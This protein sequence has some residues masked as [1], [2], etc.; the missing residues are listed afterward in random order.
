VKRLFVV[1]VAL[2]AGYVAWRR[3]SGSPA[4]R[5]LWSEVTDSLD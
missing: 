1:V 2:G 4:D 5:D 3:L